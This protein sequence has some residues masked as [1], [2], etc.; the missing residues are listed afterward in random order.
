M[1]EIVVGVENKGIP[2][3][4]FGFGKSVN[5]GSMMETTNKVISIN[6]NDIIHKTVLHKVQFAGDP[7]EVIEHNNRHYIAM[8]PLCQN[9]GLQWE[10]QYKLINRDPVLSST[11]SMMEIVAQDGKIRKMLCLPIEYLNGW[12]FKIDISRYKGELRERLILYQKRCY[13]VLFEHFNRQPVV[14]EPGSMPAEFLGAV[15]IITDRLSGFEERVVEKLSGIEAQLKRQN[16]EVI[17]EPSDAAPE[18]LKKSPAQTESPVAAF[19]M[20][21]CDFGAGYVVYKQDL[22]GQYVTYCARE[23]TP[24]LS[25]NFFFRKLYEFS[26][27]IKATARKTDGKPIPCVKGIRLKW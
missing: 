4:R 25:Y 16:E 2:C 15:R 18:N 11:I 26:Q 13:I 23:D 5:P 21:N 10:A 17:G 27:L 1:M 24:P 6:M 7:I 12:L 3:T 22:Y 20:E 8:K 14:T 19:L 9:M